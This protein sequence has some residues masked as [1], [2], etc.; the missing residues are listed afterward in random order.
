MIIKHQKPI[1]SGLPELGDE[2]VSLDGYNIIDYDF[3]L[4]D[5]VIW[6]SCGQA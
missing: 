2:I 4:Y 6:K 3:D 5:E 1:S